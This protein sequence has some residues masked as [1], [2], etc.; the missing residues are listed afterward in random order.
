MRLLQYPVTPSH[1]LGT[2]IIA[3]LYL[4]VHLDHLAGDRESHAPLALGNTST[5]RHRIGQE[6]IPPREPT[7]IGI[8]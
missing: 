7:R 6:L 8:G 5:N 1:R 2:H 3:C 4:T